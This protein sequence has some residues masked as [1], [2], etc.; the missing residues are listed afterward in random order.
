MCLGSRDLGCRGLGCRNLGCRVLGVW[1]FR[2]SGW[3]T[4]KLF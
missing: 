1:G 3:V 2:V 4:A